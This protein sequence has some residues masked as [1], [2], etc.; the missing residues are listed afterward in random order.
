MAKENS[1]PKCANVILLGMAGM[2]EFSDL[3]FLR[4]AP[5]GVTVYISFWYILLDYCIPS[6]TLNPSAKLCVITT[7]ML[8]FGMGGSTVAI[9]VLIFLVAAIA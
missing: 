6:D 8:T 3:G 2:K 7:T 5:A 4:D 9:Q 1:M